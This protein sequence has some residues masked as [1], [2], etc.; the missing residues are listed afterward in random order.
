MDLEPSL[1]DAFVCK[2]RAD[3]LNNVKPMPRDVVLEGT[4]L[5]HGYNLNA[6]LLFGSEDSLME[7]PSS[8]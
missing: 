2:A 3:G 5:P 6:Y 7:T 8:A 1:L 4:G